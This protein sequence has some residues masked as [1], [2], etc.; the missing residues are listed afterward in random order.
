MASPIKL[1]EMTRGVFIAWRLFVRDRTAVALIDDSPG[2]ALKSFWCALLILPLIFVNWALQAATPD[3]V[4]GSFGVLVDEAGW[5]RTLTVLA[6]FYV[7]RWT[8]W[9]VIMYWLAGLLDSGR[10]YRRYLFAYNWS[11]A[12]VMLPTLLYTIINFSGM[13]SDQV[14]VL[15]KLAVLIVMWAYHWFILREV[16]ELNGGF[17]AVLVAAHFILSLILGRAGTITIL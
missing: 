8:A 12:I 17:A 4:P 3:N 2:G 14:M 10:H 9:P 13:A 5:G 11:Q 15:I 7:I 6:I 1:D 16:L